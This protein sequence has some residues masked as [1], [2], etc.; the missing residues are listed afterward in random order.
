MT[1]FKA[2]PPSVVASA[3]EFRLVRRAIPRRCGRCG[4]LRH[5]DVAPSAS[6]D[7]P[8]GPGTGA[9]QGGERQAN[10]QG[11]SI[12]RGALQE[13]SDA[14]LGRESRVVE[15]WA[16]EGSDGVVLYARETGGS[17][18]MGK[19]LRG[20]GVNLGVDSDAEGE[21]GQWLRERGVHLGSGRGRDKGFML[22][23]EREHSRV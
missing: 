16:L 20:R 4:R 18:E 13:C 23:D 22:I 14:R 10:P 1:V 8:S 21:M 12:G 2:Y 11:A 17:V 5:C 15:D 19:W 7:V 6:G 3:T 9:G